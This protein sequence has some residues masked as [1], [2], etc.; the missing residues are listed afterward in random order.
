MRFLDGTADPTVN[1]VA[2]LPGVT[3]YLVG[4]A[5]GWRVG[6]PSF[7]R[8][9]YTDVYPDIDVV[10]HGD[11]GRLEYDMVLGAG[12]DPELLRLGFTGAGSMRLSGDGAL[13]LG[14]P[15]G[16]VRQE[17][18]L[19]YQTV[20]GARRTVSGEYVIEPGGGVGVDVGDF[21]PA[22]PLVI[23]PII[24]YSTYV[25]GEHSDLANAI[26][27]D[28]SGQ[29]YVTGQTDSA[30]FPTENAFDP[31]IGGGTCG[32]GFPCRDAFVTKLS[33]GGNEVIYSTYLGGNSDDMG[34]GIAVDGNGNAYVTGNTA[35]PNFPV[36]N[37]IQPTYHGGTCGETGCTGDAFLTKLSVTGSALVYSTYL[38]GAA[39]DQ[40]N[41]IAVD[42]AGRPHVVGFTISADFP[43]QNAFQPV[44]A[45]IRDAFVATLAVDGTSFAYSTFLGGEETGFDLR[46]GANAV[47]VDAL[48]STYVTGETTAQDFPVRNAFQDHCASD[49]FGSRTDAFVTKFRPSGRRLV[50]STYLGGFT[51]E[52]SMGHE[53]GLGI[54][55]S[56]QGEAFVTG[57]TSSRNFPVTDGAFQETFAGGDEGVG[58]DAF[59]TRFSASG[60]TVVY[61]TYLGGQHDDT[62]LALAVDGG[63]RAHVVGYTDS[64][65]FPTRSPFQGQLLGDFD[66]FVTKLNA[67]GTG[68][69]YSTYLG[70]SQ[71]DVI[72]FT[73]G[74]GV[75]LDAAKNAYVAGWTNTTDFPIQ[76]GFQ[77]TLQ[78]EYDTFV[79]KV[80]P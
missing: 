22:W 19:I 37:A 74:T 14:V 80:V 32:F 35:S 50:Y 24:G 23:D 44:L 43:T 28:A 11:R 54:G 4:P 5:D 63:G 49:C 52:G 3:N 7:A 51:D 76:G 60:A 21:D 26:A 13:L 45:G 48:G 47:A 8:V 55:V 2:R 18:P 79:T 53:Q 71:G 58:G 30:L 12:A 77:E 34:R 68:L 66:A 59:V 25:G 29:V 64:D 57:F 73:V 36:K 69:R 9:V 16:V 56:A 27:V 46:E 62:G 67:S 15:G 17:P 78:G 40:G 33:A 6:I 31:T 42:A 61:S 65:D 38:G 75:G 1:G 72:A 41:G 20:R 39:D 10:F 70:G